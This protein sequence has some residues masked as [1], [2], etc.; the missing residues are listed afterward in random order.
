MT[1]DLDKTR[2]ENGALLQ[3]RKEGKD[4]AEKMVSL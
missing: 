4:L 2:S 1:D 3:D